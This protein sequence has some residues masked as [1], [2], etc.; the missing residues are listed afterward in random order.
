MDHL[1]GK[2]DEEV[3]MQIGYIKYVPKNAKYF[4]FVS[5]SQIE[6]LYENARIVVSHAGIGCIISA[7]KHNK[8]NIIVPRRE[9]YKEHFDD[10]QVEIAQ[11]L[12]RECKIKVLWDIKG[13]G[14]AINNIDTNIADFKEDNNLITSLRSYLETLNI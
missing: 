6:C 3:I 9:M 8:P 7:S 1:A 12:E 5:N 13:L 4:N 2:I 11:E 10:H 14:D